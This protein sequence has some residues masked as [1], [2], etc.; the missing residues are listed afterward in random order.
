MEIIFF[1][2]F[3]SAQTKGN[4]KKMY[5]LKKQTLVFLPIITFSVAF[6]D[7]Y[8]S[9]MGEWLRKNN[10]KARDGSFKPLGNPLIKMVRKKNGARQQ[11]SFMSLIFTAT[12]YFNQ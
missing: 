5:S 3:Y 2:I 4:H 9:L 6:L 7:H 8:V 1:L 10:R 12:L 11:R